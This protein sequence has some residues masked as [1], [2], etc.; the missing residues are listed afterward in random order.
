MDNEDIETI[1]IG[2]MERVGQTQGNCDPRWSHPAIIAPII[3][4]DPNYAPAPGSADIRVMRMRLV[5]TRHQMWPHSPGR[6]RV[7]REDPGYSQA[8]V[9]QRIMILKLLNLLTTSS[10]TIIHG[11]L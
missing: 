10:N 2:D 6:A 3:T 8:L 11:Q 4:A 7:P 1:T 5:L 9:E